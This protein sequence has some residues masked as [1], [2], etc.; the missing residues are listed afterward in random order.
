VATTSVSIKG[1]TSL[2]NK[3]RALV[4]STR[5]AVREAVATTALLI[6]SDAKRFAPVDTGRLRSSIHAAIAS[7]GL[8]ATVVTNVVYAGVQEF[9]STRQKPQPFLGPA[10]EKNRGAF[11]ANLKRAGLSV[12]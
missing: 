8:S 6:E 7:N 2:G 4:P 11:I 1:L 12:K 5:A 3:L 10:F 9:G